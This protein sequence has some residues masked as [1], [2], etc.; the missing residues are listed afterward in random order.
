MDT[1]TNMWVDGS[2]RHISCINLTN[3][4]QLLN[5]RLYTFNYWRERRKK[6]DEYT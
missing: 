3:H 2:V 6:T 4:L 1:L 5:N